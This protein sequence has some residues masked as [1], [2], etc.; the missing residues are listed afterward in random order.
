MVVEVEA[1]KSRGGL[2]GE[3]RT[4]KKAFVDQD[5]FDV[6]RLQGVEW[7]RAEKS[8]GSEHNMFGKNWGALPYSPG[9]GLLTAEGRSE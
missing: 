3:G 1:V 8:H 6:F 9:G 4:T 5:A 7:G 2:G